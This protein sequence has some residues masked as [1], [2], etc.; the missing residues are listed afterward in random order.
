MINLVFCLF[1]TDNSWC[2]CRG[3]GIM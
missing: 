2:Y 1:T 3:T